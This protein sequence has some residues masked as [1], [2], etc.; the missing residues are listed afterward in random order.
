M[1]KR[2]GKVLR[3]GGSAGES[4]HLH[5]RPSPRGLL[6]C[7]PVVRRGTLRAV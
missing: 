3:I 4:Y 2:I 6:M 1:A 5:R 7:E